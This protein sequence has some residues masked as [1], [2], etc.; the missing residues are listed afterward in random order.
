MFFK[1]GSKLGSIFRHFIIDL[2]HS[3][4]ISSILKFCSVHNFLSIDAILTKPLLIKSSWREPSIGKMGSILR[5]LWV[6]HCHDPI[7][8]FRF[9]ILG[10]LGRDFESLNFALK[11][12][13]RPF[14]KNIGIFLL[15]YFFIILF[16]CY[17]FFIYL[18]DLYLQKG[19]MFIIYM[20]STFYSVF[21]FVP[22]I[23]R[24]MSILHMLVYDIRPIHSGYWYPYSIV[25][26]LHLWVYIYLYPLHW[27]TIL[28]YV[29][30]LYP[31]AK[32]KLISHKVSTNLISVPLFIII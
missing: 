10:I 28:S 31:I 4:I 19:I 18:Y 25:I 1:T 9:G 22:T 12:D 20:I 8:V 17:F 26:Y 3:I 24:W 23:S 13:W 7:Y 5:K 6:K 2:N 29:L 32:D 11:K 21:E 16:L 27:H 30:L 14:R 15:F